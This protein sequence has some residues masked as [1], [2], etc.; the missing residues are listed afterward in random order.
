MSFQCKSVATTPEDGSVFCFGVTLR[1]YV[2]K[3]QAN[4]KPIEQLLNGYVV[5]VLESVFD[6]ACLKL[7]RKVRR[8]A[9]EGI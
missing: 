2:G 1:L 6:S 5:K 4:L 9:A 7:S 3:L 8:T